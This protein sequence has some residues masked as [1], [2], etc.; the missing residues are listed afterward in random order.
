MTRSFDDPKSANLSI[1]LAP[2][3]DLRADTPHFNATI[4]GRVDLTADANNCAP[5]YRLSDENFDIGLRAR[6]VEETFLPRIVLAGFGD[7]PS[8]P[9]ARRFNSL[10]SGAVQFFKGAPGDPACDPMAP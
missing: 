10:R 7:E 5:L 8:D 4:E 3:M 2:G 9:E 1:R 6:W